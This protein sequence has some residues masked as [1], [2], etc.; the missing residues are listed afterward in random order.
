MRSSWIKDRGNFETVKQ[1]KKYVDGKRKY[2]KRAALGSGVEADWIL[3]GS[4]GVPSDHFEG[5]ICSERDEGRGAL[6]E[7]FV[8]VFWVGSP[9]TDRESEGSK[10]FRE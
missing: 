1:K 8:K 6:K 7:A 10:E 2:I 5:A 9:G 4:G 3:G